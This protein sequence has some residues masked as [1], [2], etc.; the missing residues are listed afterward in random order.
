MAQLEIISNHKIAE[1]YFKIR[2]KG[3][4][5]KFVPG[6]FVNL[7][8]G[9]E[10]G[11]L[12]KR[13]I[14]VYDYN[15]GVITLIY[16]V[17]GK[18]TAALSKMKGGRLAAEYF[19]GNGFVLEEN[20][21]RIMLIGGGMGAAPLFSVMRC[22]RDKE[23]FPYLGF[24]DKERIILKEEYE[25]LSETVISTDDGSFG[26][27]GFI[28]NIAV[29]DIEKIKP[30]VILACGPKPMLKALTL[31]KDVKVLVSVEE[32]MGCGIGACLVC[33]CETVNGNK[34]VCKDGPV[35]DIK[36]LKL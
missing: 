26:H 5:K 31:L 28:T 8:V 3:D 25:S 23:F 14:S 18:G 17:K 11:I 20:E 35:F 34:R 9:H 19:L 29:K 21:K 4:I 6:Q 30:D 16:E 10:D 12:L 27:K 13:P 2:L 33:V 22:Y 1:G 24:S 15:E 7:S 36:E 32:R